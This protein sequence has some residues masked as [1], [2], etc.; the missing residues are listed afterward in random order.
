MTSGYAMI[1]LTGPDAFSVLQRGTEISLA[2]PSASATRAF[3]GYP[4]LLYAHSDGDGDGGGYRL[5]VPRA[6]LEGLWALLERYSAQ[7]AA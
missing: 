6:Y 7:A 2:E 5:H 1:A 4:V 3:G